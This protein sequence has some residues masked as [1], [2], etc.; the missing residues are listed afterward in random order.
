MEVSSNSIIGVYDYVED[1]EMVEPKQPHSY[2]MNEK[3]YDL[4]VKAYRPE[5]QATLNELKGRI[6]HISYEQFQDALQMTVKQFQVQATESKS[7]ED[8]RCV[9][10]VQPGKS[11]KWVTEVAIKKGF[12]ADKYVCLGEEGANNLAYSLNYI[13][14]EDKQLFKNVIII[15]DGSFSGNQMANNV[16]SAHRLL[17][18]KFREN[19]TFHV[20]IP[21]ITKTAREKINDLSKK[22]VSVQLYYAE[23]MPI[24]NELVKASQLS[25]LLEVLWPKAQDRLEK[26]KTT[27]G[28]WF[29]HKIPNS[30]SFPEVLAKGFVTKPK[31]AQLDADIPFLPDVQPPYK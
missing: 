20:L 1:S 9:S 24:V 23:E 3:Q 22:G 25:K 4:W 16:S 10:L 30:M 6:K 28:Y 21:F 7:D 13:S 8:F 18:E 12:N 2:K 31:D 14:L 17:K 26:G 5:F 15:D 29:D 19:S 11:Q 27:S